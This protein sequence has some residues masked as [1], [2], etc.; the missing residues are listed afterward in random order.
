MSLQDS[1]REVISLAEEALAE[2]EDDT[3]EPGAFSP[4]SYISDALDSLTDALRA[5]KEKA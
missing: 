5:T 4:Y 3:E 1:I 2:A